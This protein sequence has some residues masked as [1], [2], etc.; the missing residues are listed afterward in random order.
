VCYGEQIL[1]FLIPYSSLYNFQ[2]EGSNG[3]GVLVSHYVVTNELPLMPSWLLR[4]DQE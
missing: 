4:E 3:N 2:R 1:Q